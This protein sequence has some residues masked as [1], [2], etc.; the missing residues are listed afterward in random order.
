MS[1]LN[2][3]IQKEIA[4]MD[5]VNRMLWANTFKDSSAEDMVL[6]VREICKN[7]DSNYITSM[8]DCI[9][10][11][12]LEKTKLQGIADIIEELFL[13]SKDTVYLCK[14]LFLI[15][16]RIGNASLARFYLDLCH[17]DL[18]TDN[19]F[20]KAAFFYSLIPLHELS[21]NYHQNNLS[22]DYCVDGQSFSY[23]VFS[24][25]DEIGQNMTLLKTRFGSIIFDCGAKCSVD[26]AIMISLRDLGDFLSATETKKEDVKAIIISHA[27]LDHYGSLKTIIDAGFDIKKIF[28]SDGTKKLISAV[29]QTTFPLAQIRPISEFFVANNDIKIKSFANGHIVGSECYLV[30]FDNIN[31][32]YSGDYCLHDQR[33]VKGL[34]PVL[35]NNED[36]VK[37]TDIDCLITESTYG[38]SQQ[39]LKHNDAENALV[40]FVD[41]LLNMGYK[42]FLPSFAV[43][44][45]QELALILNERHSVLLDGLAITVSQIYENISGIAI[46]NKNTRYNVEDTENRK[47]NFDSN[48]IIIAS[49]GM[50]AKNSTSYNYVKSFLHS[51]EKI[52]IIKTGFINSESFGKSLLDEWKSDDNILL[53]ISLSAHASYDEI[54]ELINELNPRNIVSIHGKGI[55][56]VDVDEKDSM[57]IKTMSGNALKEDGNGTVA[58][59]FECKN[60][61][62][63]DLIC[64]PIKGMEEGSAIEESTVDS[65]SQDER[66][67]ISDSQ[68]RGK[69]DNI[70]KTGKSLHDNGIS[71]QKSP[72]FSTACKLA[73]RFLKL[74]PYYE[75]VYAYL[76]NLKSYDDFW[77]YVADGVEHDYG[78]KAEEPLHPTIATNDTLKSEQTINQV[79][80][81]NED[82]RG[83]LRKDIYENV[84]IAGN[85]RIPREVE[86]AYLKIIDLLFTDYKRL[87]WSDFSI[88]K[89]MCNRCIKQDQQDWNT[90]F[91]YLG[92][93]DLSVLESFVKDSAFIRD[94]VNKGNYDAIPRF[95]E[96]YAVLLKS[97]RF[98]IDSN[99]YALSTF[100]ES[101][102][103]TRDKT[104]PTTIEV[105]NLSVGTYNLLYNAKI[106]SLEELVKL[107]DEELLDIKGMKKKSAREIKT[108]LAKIKAKSIIEGSGIS[109]DFALSSV[110]SENESFSYQTGFEKDYKTQ[111][112]V[113]IVKMGE[114]DY[115]V[116][117]K[118][119]GGVPYF[120]L[121]E[122]RS[123]TSNHFYTLE[124]AKDEA[125]RLR[126]MI[127]ST[128]PN[129]EIVELDIENYPKTAKNF[130]DIK[131]TYVDSDGQVIFG[132]TTEGKLRVLSSEEDNYYVFIDKR[133]YR[134]K[135][136]EKIDKYAQNLECD[137]RK[138][139]FELA[140][141][142][143]LDMSLSNLRFE[144]YKAKELIK[145]F[146]WD[147]ELFAY[148]RLFYEAYIEGI[149]DSIKI[150]KECL[151]MP[152]DW[153][154]YILDLSADNDIP[155]LN[156]YGSI[157]GIGTYKI[158]LCKKG[159]SVTISQK[160]N[161]ILVVII[162]NDTDRQAVID[163]YKINSNW[164]FTFDV[165]K[166][167][168]AKKR[169]GNRIEDVVSSVF[170]LNGD[171]NYHGIAEEWVD[172]LIPY[173]DNDEYG[174][175]D[176]QDDLKK[177]YI[178]IIQLIFN[179]P[180][181]LVYKDFNTLKGMCTRCIRKNKAD[182]QTTYMYLGC[183]D[184]DTL[185]SFIRD[186]K[187]VRN[188]LKE[189]I[190]DDV[191]TFVNEYKD[192]LLYALNMLTDTDQK[193]HE[194]K[195][196]LSIGAKENERSKLDTEPE[197]NN[198]YVETLSSTAEGAII[199]EKW[200]GALNM[201]I[202][203]LGFSIRTY[204]CLH[205]AKIL[206]VKQLSEMT[207]YQLYK[208][209]NLGEKGVDEIKVK[210][211][212]LDLK[213]QDRTNFEFET[214]PVYEQVKNDDFKIE[215]NILVKYLG[216]AENV[217]IPQGIKAIC[218]GAFHENKTVKSIFLPNGV[219]VVG[220]A[221]FYNCSSLTD[222]SLPNTLKKIEDYAFF[223]CES[224]TAIRFPYELIKIGERAFNQCKS[225]TSIEIPDSVEFIGSMAFTQCKLLNRVFIGNGVRYIGEYAFSSCKNLNYVKL[226]KKL[227]TI[228]RG[229]FRGCHRLTTIIF[230]QEIKT[231]GE[232]AFNNV[233][234]VCCDIPYGVE[235]IDS[236]AFYAS[237]ELE[238]I[239]IPKSIKIIKD[240]AFGH[241]KKLKTVIFDGSES[242]WAKIEKGDDLFIRSQ[243]D[244]VQFQ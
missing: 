149:T 139:G 178:R 15:Y 188:L 106:L 218:G 34:N 184:D 196:G 94:E 31:I 167:K 147:N 63:E 197:Q 57:E 152:K 224:L 126:K 116:S 29:A 77:K 173:L 138:M 37:T 214:L 59:E 108:K 230:P 211:G 18:G 157:P 131:E 52:A 32:I 228:E 161:S 118:I 25:S 114:S 41:K 60:D 205:R 47:R 76:F 192:I 222:I 124:A 219:E 199:E 242:E 186:S 128:S 195:Q 97:V 110:E 23:S 203:Q 146:E 85:N 207:E 11:L 174:N 162:D 233:G 83:A 5:I 213:L 2:K 43:G 187:K 36:A 151:L 176:I 181:A 123:H 193:V 26:S 119:H 158:I 209:R 55:A 243:T 144:I 216:T 96:K 194:T 53:D 93:P 121:L 33:T 127:L 137:Y 120:K 8:L 98:H 163:E 212:E 141:K 156:Q 234:F 220:K 95:A 81:T 164:Y 75:K 155:H 239:R 58:D 111:S 61:K 80:R 100:K 170:R 82:E 165:P 39:Y 142:V 201:S 215:G 183:P 56:H 148:D 153:D 198:C 10:A 20:T 68:C 38:H 136:Y 40:H 3:Y 42:V 225:L 19:E 166:S 134:K 28:M 117:E 168:N 22:R 13:V 30:S 86:S 129:C 54:I 191:Q 4:D 244:N 103:A 217:I 71:L 204:N 17:N 64:S 92:K 171:S 46:Y 16:H 232:K 132:V 240:N 78:F 87:K 105:L 135:L 175:N 104:Q 109:D 102:E 160:D 62:T 150:Q 69:L 159:E 115:Y 99:S 202:E 74:N 130:T 231:I 154:I 101:L 113:M 182:W 200:N 84:K 238:M 24:F 177:E 206:N 7:K 6:T 235:E 125:D 14:Y 67:Q 107:T 169:F 236:Q 210:L 35:I 185:N 189:G 70:Y 143:A 208:V 48:N 88:L 9:L 79:L 72:S 221:A 12:E 237:Q 90:T 180:H 91:F 50:L 66:I 49:S 241:L 223:S 226:S 227:K 51:G 172:A 44:R 27:H 145:S 179:N 73:L 89:G 1:P 21:K 112:D 229:V 65:K 133:I 45:S 140:Y 190:Y 122:S